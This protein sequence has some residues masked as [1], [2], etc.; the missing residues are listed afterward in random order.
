MSGIPS[1]LFK[2]KSNIYEESYTDNTYLLKGNGE[3]EKRRVTEPVGNSMDLD[4]IMTMQKGVEMVENKPEPITA[5][6]EEPEDFALHTQEV[7]PYGDQLCL[8][9]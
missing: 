9:P 5:S 4:Q 1:S 7:M 2:R 8:T 6:F 3:T